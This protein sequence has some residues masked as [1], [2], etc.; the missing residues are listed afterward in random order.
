MLSQKSIF[1]F[2]PLL[3]LSFSCLPLNNEQQSDLH[4]QGNRDISKV[5]VYRYGGN[6]IEDMDKH[7][8]EE[9]SE[10]G[11]VG[12]A[13]KKSVMRTFTVDH[14][15][16]LEP[17]ADNAPGWPPMPRKS[18]TKT[19]TTSNDNT[20][21]FG[22]EGEFL[23]VVKWAAQN[24]WTVGVSTARQLVLIK[25][26]PTQKEML[27]KFDDER[28]TWV[29]EIDDGHEYVGLCVYTAS[30]KNSYR[31]SG[32]VSIGGNGVVNNSEFSKLTEVSLYSGF[33]E[34]EEGDTIPSLNNFC[35][36]VY[37]GLVKDQV[38]K[39][40]EMSLLSEASFAANPNSI[41]LAVNAALFGRNIKG[42]LIE[43][44]NW[45]VEQAQVFPDGDYV[46]I[47]GSLKRNT[48]AHMSDI[49]S[50]R[51]EYQNN[52][53]LDKLV[54]FS[55]NSLDKSYRDAALKIV[56]AICHD[57]NL[58]YRTPGAP[59]MWEELTNVFPIDSNWDS[60]PPF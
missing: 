56:D 39:D 49:V 40:L 54:Q 46:R 27:I 31:F 28:E 51:C 3:A 19:L 33:F 7:S 58:E 17:P 50:Y 42:A 12:D 53:E 16:N 37:E 6:L 43:G 2:F 52:E 20:I 22:Y 24:H 15:I 60:L 44:H 25:N 11:I 1:I 30:A 8:D 9:L 48:K 29:P 32:G 21:H 47:M 5:K 41:S 38:K 18:L 34:I 13:V 57:G 35:L 26:T 45:D 4:A 10:L 14:I 55:Q 23:K 36:D 59:R